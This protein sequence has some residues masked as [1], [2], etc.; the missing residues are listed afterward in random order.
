M[1]QG[2]A[3]LAAIF[4]A[5]A[6]FLVFAKGYPCILDVGAESC[7]YSVPSASAWRAATIAATSPTLPIPRSSGIF[8]VCLSVFACAMTVAKYFVLTGP[9]EKYREYIPNWV[10]IG[11]MMVVPVPCIGIAIMMGAL[12]SLVWHR[13][14]RRTHDEYLFSVIAGMISGEGIGGIFN[15]ILAIAG[16][17]AG[18]SIG[19]PAGRC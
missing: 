3:S 9:R 19:C 7:E 4:L 6:L 11:I 10:A 16:V 2:I 1:A 17:S 5:P 12:I 8:A 13:F 15:A 18:T 14:W